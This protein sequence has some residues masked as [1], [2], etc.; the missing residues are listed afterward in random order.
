MQIGTN[1]EFPKHLGDIPENVRVPDGN[2][3]KFVLYGVGILDYKFNAS[4]STWKICKGETFLVNNLEDF[5]SFNA[6]SLVATTSS[7]A[8][9]QHGNTHNGALKSLIPGDTSFATGQSV[10]FDYDT[11]KK[12]VRWSLAKVK[13]SQGVFS[14]ITHMLG[15]HSSIHDLSEGSYPD[16]YVRSITIDL[17][18]LYYRKE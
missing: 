16:G 4:D 18:N 7:N 10:S 8:L 2:V 14:D 11:K 13:T 17:T 12:I 6:S 1:T 3:F 15:Y 9:D 5:S